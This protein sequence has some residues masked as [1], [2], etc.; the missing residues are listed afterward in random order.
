MPHDQL[1]SLARQSCVSTT[2]LRDA[3]LHHASVTVNRANA[4]RR[5]RVNPEQLTAAMSA[6]DIHKQCT[7]EFLREWLT[8]RDASVRTS[9][10]KKAQLVEAV[11]RCLRNIAAQ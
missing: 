9:G 3:I 5:R 11:M 7:A 6:S 4:G 10:L 8:Q 1:Y 2:D